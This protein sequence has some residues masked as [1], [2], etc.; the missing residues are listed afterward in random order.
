MT[1]RHR[2]QQTRQRQVLGPDAPRSVNFNHRLTD[3]SSNTPVGWRAAWHCWQLSWWHWVTTTTTTLHP[4]NGLFSRTTWVSWCQKSKT[5]LDL[6]EA[7]DDGILECSGISWTICK[8]SAP[9]C[10]Q[11]TTPTPHPLNFYRPD[12]LPGAQPTVS[13]HW[14][15]TED[16]E[17]NWRV[18]VNWAW[19]DR[20]LDDHFS[21][22][23]SWK[24]GRVSRGVAAGCA[25]LVVRR[26]S[27]T[28]RRRP[29]Y[30]TS[31]THSQIDIVNVVTYLI[32]SVGGL[33]IYLS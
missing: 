19:C 23:S 13:K 28:T 15:H 2:D 10:R 17:L 9:R 30:T 27:A 25:G 32:R 18:N 24:P 33:L 16:T 8:Q 7:R 20:I 5:S 6:S 12:A 22:D 29:H 3:P 1:L 4:F 11:M 14:R 26:R 31:T 21:Y